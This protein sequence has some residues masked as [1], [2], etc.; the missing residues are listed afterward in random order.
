LTSLAQ[1]GKTGAAL[2]RPNKGDSK[3]V[4]TE[5]TGANTR[6]SANLESGATWARAAGAANKAPTSVSVNSEAVK[7]RCVRPRSMTMLDRLS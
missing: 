4:T 6:S 3:A 7:K 5:V 2:G 1:L